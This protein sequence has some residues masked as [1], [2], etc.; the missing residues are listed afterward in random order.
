M[1]LPGMRPGRKGALLRIN[2]RGL[3]DVNTARVVATRSEERSVEQAQRDIYD[4]HRH[5]VYSLAYYMTA[6][7][8]EAEQ[9]LTQTFVH[10]FSTTPKPDGTAIDTALIGQLR[11][12]FTLTPAEISPSIPKGEIGEQNIRRTDLEEAI[13]CLPPAERL[14]FLLRDVEGYSP[15]AISQLT[16]FPRAQ[17]NRTVFAARI[18]LRSILA[19]MQ[20]RQIA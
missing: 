15:E 8:V 1:N 5:R 16:G 14:L 10:V 7:E 2:A 3:F 6:N 13:H 18:H 11:S 12:R 17:V 4:S 19:E 9:I 20:S